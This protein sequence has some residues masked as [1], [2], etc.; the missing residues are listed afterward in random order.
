MWDSA[1]EIATAW[2]EK[3]RAY[4]VERHQ[5]CPWCG[6]AHCVFR[7][8]RP[9][10]EQFACSVCDFFTCHTFEDNHYFVTPGE[11]ASSLEPAAAR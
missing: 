8:R 10:R 6:A 1:D 7:T 3:A 11:S 2:F 9:E 4:Y 5:A